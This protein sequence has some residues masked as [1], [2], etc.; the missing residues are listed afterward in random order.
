MRDARECGALWN[1]WCW[2]MW[3]AGE[4][5]TA[6]NVAGWGMLEAWECGRLGN[7]GSVGGWEMRAAG[8]CE[9]LGNAGGQGI[10]EA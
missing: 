9:R 3:E 5:W 2:G 6:G 1:A 7:A 10:R 8:E 4:G